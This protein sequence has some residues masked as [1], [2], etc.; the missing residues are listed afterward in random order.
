MRFVRPFDS[1]TLDDLALVG[2]KNAS[3]GEMIQELTPLGVRVPNGFALTAGAYR[4][5]VEQPKVHRALEAALVDLDPGNVTSLRAC[6][7]A[8]RKAIREAP[9]L[10][11]LEDELATA[12]AALSHESGED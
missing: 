5:V 4:A 9:L 1:L 10:D 12:Y 8:A 6:G 11:Q 7:A 3:F 2:G